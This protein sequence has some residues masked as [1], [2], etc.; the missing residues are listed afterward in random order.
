M[1]FK[2]TFARFARHNI[3][4]SLHGGILFLFAWLLL[5][6]LEF[7]LNFTDLSDII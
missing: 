6:L 3:P 1:H 5:I 4:T 7:D 2:K